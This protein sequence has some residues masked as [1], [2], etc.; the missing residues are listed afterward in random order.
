MVCRLIVLALSAALVACPSISPPPK[1]AAGGSAS[2]SDDTPASRAEYATE[3][4]ASPS[5][6]SAVTPLIERI[7]RERGE[8]PRADAV[9]SELGQWA[10]SA[11]AH[12]LELDGPVI[13]GMAR[14]L[15]YVGPAP[16][17]VF[18]SA[19]SGDPEIED[20]LRKHVESIPSNVHL[21]RFGIGGVAGADLSVV[22][23]AAIELE[24][25][26]FPKR[27]APGASVTLEAQA[28]ERFE[29]A[30]LAITMPDGTVRST[31][32]ATRDINAP[33]QFGGAGVYRIELF[34]E[35]A[36]GPVV[37]ANFPVYAG[38]E[39]PAV[40]MR[41]AV[42]GES[43]PLDAPAVA[44]RMFELLGRARADAHLAPLTQDE[45]LAEMA[46]AHSEDMADHGFFGHVSPT[47]GGLEER[48]KRAQRVMSKSGE[49]IALSDSA[50][51][52]HQQ[53]MDSPGHRGAML[54]PNFT[55]VGFGIVVRG[56]R[57]YATL[58]FARK[59]GATVETAP[60]LIKKAVTRGRQS[61]GLA[62]LTDDDA[63][64][65]A[66]QAGIRSLSGD[67]LPRALEA[68]K[69]SLTRDRRTDRATCIGLLV[70]AD[71]ANFELPPAASSP[72][73][74]SMGLGVVPSDAGPEVFRVLLIV[75][76]K[77]GG[78]LACQ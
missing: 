45:S 75:Q 57:V 72:S 51:H 2:A 53:L 25:K 6:T 29:R 32:T 66:A 42:T 76:A 64:T 68:A 41:A 40:R 13:E 74:G 38:V 73:A 78:T 33:I 47:L 60:A 54:D 8:H 7:L 34:G 61:K 16:H 11:Y 35:G 12:K 26:P 46:R 69:A 36:S 22:A 49:N 67:A 70:T 77:P 15:G 71:P 43:G 63:L 18:V 65:R 28:G 1:E 52:A 55:H 30:R 10:A 56:D 14:R 27:V 48:L 31:K 37:I 23:L 59:T 62:P 39:E 4:G 9:L 24:L 44:A 5:P 17:L 58:I 21:T 19:R 20:A 50:D 3:L